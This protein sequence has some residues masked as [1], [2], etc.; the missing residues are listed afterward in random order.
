VILKPHLF[1]LFQFDAHFS[2]SY[3]RLC[4]P[5]STYLSFFFSM[6]TESRNW[7]NTLLT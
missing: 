2:N 3:W 5:L 1:L 6:Q 7:T 4:C